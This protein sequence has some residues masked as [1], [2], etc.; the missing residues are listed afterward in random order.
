MVPRYVR[1]ALAQVVYENLRDGRVVATVPP[2]KGVIAFGVD[3]RSA[4]VGLLSGQPHYNAHR[5]EADVS[6]RRT[7]RA[8]PCST[9]MGSPQRSRV[10]PCGLASPDSTRRGAA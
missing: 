7:M 10:S 6:K 8:A 9:T 4:T 2:C 1:E 5:R 3:H